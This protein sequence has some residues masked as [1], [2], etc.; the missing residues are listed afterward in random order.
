[1][2]VWLTRTGGVLRAVSPMDQ[3]EMAKMPDGKTFECNITYR[4]S[5]K[6]ERWY[7]GLVARV[8][9][10]TGALYSNEA[11]HEA[12][13]SAV[14]AMDYIPGLAGQPGRFQNKS[15]ANMEGP[16]FRA[17]VNAAIDFILA[18]LL[19]GQPRSKF[20]REVERYANVSLSDALAE[21]EKYDKP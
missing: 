17:Y 21:S 18:E 13:K 11:F 5:A 6:M 12:L 9:Q 19:P 14:G 10:A 1:M 7:R 16:E 3:D 15:N 8:N 2:K 4:R 20:M